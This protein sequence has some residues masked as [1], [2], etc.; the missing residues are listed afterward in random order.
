MFNGSGAPATWTSNH[1]NH[2]MNAETE[3]DVSS[4]R[5]GGFWW[6][7]LRWLWQSS[8]SSLTRYAPDLDTPYWRFWTKAQPFVVAAS[9]FVGLPFGWQA[10]FWMGAIRLTF[11]LHAQCTVNSI[12]HMKK[13]VAPGEDSSQNLLWLGFFQWFQG[14]NWHG[15]HHAEPNSAQLG[16]SWRQPDLG[17]AFIYVMEKVG[18]A[19]RVRR[20]KDVARKAA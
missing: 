1:R 17:W 3:A 16:W 20:R 5:I 13:G 6:A 12:A 18:L 19:S 9:L 15:N 8:Q 14:E 10:F 11:S 4:P 7:H 2:H